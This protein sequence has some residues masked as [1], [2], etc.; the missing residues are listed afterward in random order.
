M[1]ARTGVRPPTGGRSVPAAAD[2]VV[3]S[4]FRFCADGTRA[5]CVATAAD[6]RHV[7][8]GWTL[9]PAG[10]RPVLRTPLGTDPAWTQ[11][12]PLDDTSVL[13]SWYG[14]RGAQSLARLTG[15]GPRGT[16]AVPV[17]RPLRLLPAP[18]G[19]G[20][21]ALGVSGGAADDTLVVA[22][23]EDEPRFEERAR[24]PGR[25]LGG[26]VLGDRVL[27]TRLL[28]GV[29]EPVVLDLR[30]GGLRPLTAGGDPAHVL[31]AAAGR[32]LLA[33][34]TREGGR[35][36][37][38]D[39]DVAAP[40]REVR[41]ET[42]LPGTVHPL[43]LAPTGDRLALLTT[44]GARSYLA[45][46]DPV[47]GAARHVDMPPG[48][49]LPT[50]AW[51]GHG[52][53]LPHSDPGR[54]RTLGWLPPDG[55]A[56]ELAEP[57]RPGHRPARLETFPGADGPV[58]AVVYGPDWRTASRVVLALHGG[59]NSRWTLGY[60]PLLQA[61][62]AAGLAVVAPNQRG[63]TGYGAAHTLAISGAWGGPDLAD[64]TA[65]G[66]HLTGVRGDRRER[67][68]LYGV[69]YGAYLALLT[70]AA[71]PEGWAACAAVAPFLSGPRLHADGSQQVRGMVERLDGL[72]ALHDR[73]GPRDVERL[74]PALEAPLLLVHGARDD[75][76]PV[77]HSRALAAR[78][79]ALGR[80]PG[81]D[82]H[83]L[84]LPDRGHA[85]LGAGTDDPVVAS[86]VRFLT[87]RGRPAP[88]GTR[89]REGR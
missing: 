63:S 79:T 75:S 67:P 65:I 9:G 47:S 27:F 51:T 6:G 23:R 38:A 61:M 78:L 18:A 71:E 73:L 35:L 16:V 89:G 8:E 82:F 58:E 76:V 24:V 2:T 39:V 74:A 28:D 31:A 43:A 14:A 34:V 88:S 13:A 19:S 44:S 54:P 83:Y 10:P 32:V 11:L 64:V 20:L 53:W 77:A 49:L 15:E 33:R 66:R 21:L 5:A 30:D 86:V 3:R 80:R 81:T 7:A 4:S 45:V 41:G 36:A 69:S 26:T 22:V 57:A 1:S 40:A 68:A 48:D 72:T 46:L 52:L 50:A 55:T 25:L 17:T 70:A 56:L 37:L 29:P 42:G 85:V 59:P 12:L 60:D 84:E 62:A 87:G